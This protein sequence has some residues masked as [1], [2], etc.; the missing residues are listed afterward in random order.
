MR[1]AVYYNWF[2]DTWPTKPVWTP[3]LGYYDSTLGTYQAH[4]AMMPYARCRAGISSWWGPTSA[5]SL[6]FD[7]QL[8]AAEGTTFR[9][10]LYYETEG[11]S[12]PQSNV[13]A[14]DLTYAFNRWASHP[15]YLRKQGKP[16]IFA[17]AGAPD[18][19]FMCDRWKIANDG[20]FYTVLKVFRGF[21]NVASLPKT[22]SLPTWLPRPHCSRCNGATLNP[23][24]LI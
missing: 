17:Y 15:N 3:S 1:A 2:P 22:N 10:C 8:R 16:V 12:D 20:R 13:L 11:Y 23:S 19:P 7:D 9:W 5:Y 6:R 21:E 14:Q 4:I 18:G 24:R